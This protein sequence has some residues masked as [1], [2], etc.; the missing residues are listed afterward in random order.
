MN[1]VVDFETL[2]LSENSIILECSIIYFNLYDNVD[3]TLKENLDNYFQYLLDRGEKI[4]FNINKQ[5]LRRSIEPETLKWWSKQNPKI[6]NKCIYNNNSTYDTDVLIPFIESY[7]NKY[8]NDKKIIIW[9]RG[10]LDIKIL[11]NIAKEHNQNLPWKYVD[12]RECRTKIASERT[13]IYQIAKLLDKKGDYNFI[14][15]DMANTHDSIHDCAIDAINMIYMNQQKIKLLK[16]LANK[17]T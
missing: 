16:E 3:F 6:L 13:T 7:I 9:S 10:E 12:W 5:I 14:K 11:N 2:G 4:Q 15:P 1:I 8:N 17:N